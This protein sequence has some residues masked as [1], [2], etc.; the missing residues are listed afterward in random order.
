MWNRI[1]AE[2]PSTYFAIIV[3]HLGTVDYLQFKPL[4]QMNI[5]LM[6][7]QIIMFS[8]VETLVYQ[9]ALFTLIAYYYIHEKLY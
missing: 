8:N 5:Q 1:L 2:V 4:R 7:I 9:N 3:L 6:N